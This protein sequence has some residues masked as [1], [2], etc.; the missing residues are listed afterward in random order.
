M[1][2]EAEGLQLRANPD[3]RAA[4]APDANGLA[5]LAK[6][7]T[8]S[9]EGI[10]RELRA[11]IVQAQTQTLR[12]RTAFDAI[13]QGVCYFD[14]ED[15]VLL[16]NRRF[17]EIY[18]LAP[19]QIRPGATLREIVELRVA[20]GT[21][22]AASAD[23]YLSFCASNHLS[24]ESIVWMTELRDG[25][26]IQMRR[27]PMPGGGCVVTYEDITELKAA[28]AAANERLSLQALI[29]RL[30]DNLW[31]KD[32]NSR[33]VIANQVTATRMGMAGPAEL[34][35]KTDLELLPPEI[36]RK[37]FAD[38]QEIIRTGHPMIDEEEY[39]SKTWIS[40]TKVPLRNERNEIFGVAGISRDITTRRLEDA[41]R[42]EQ[43]KILEMIAMSAPL[44]D[45]L[46]HLVLLME[47]QFKGIAGSILLVDE[48]GSRLRHGAAPSLPDTYAKAIDGLR[49]GPKVGPCGTAAYRREAVVVADIMT[50]PL[51]GD[52]KS[53]AAE[54]GLRSCWATP[55]LSHQGAVLGTFAM[56]SKEVR[57]PSDAELRLVDVATRI[58]GIAIERKLAEDRIHFM[59]NHDA[60]TGL[61]NR[62]LL[63]DR[64]S[65]AMLHARRDDRWVTALFT[66]IDN[67][68]FVNDSLGHNAGDELL[69]TIA[70]RMSDCIRATDTVV[71]LGGDEFV[72]VLSDQPK[73]ADTISQTVRKLQATISA[74]IRLEDHD[75]TITVSIGIASYPDD[76][77]DVDTL[78]GNADAAM[79]RAKEIGRDNFQFYT[80]ELNTK[81]HSKFLLQEELRAAVARSE[82]VLHYQPQVDL[83]TG[84]VF[85]VEAL[86][87]WNHPRL[88]LVPPLKFIPIAEESGLIVP[89]GDWVLNEACR[90]NKAWQ[91]A[92][93]PPIAVC[94]NVSARQFR[95]G[96]L[97]AQVTNAL[98]QTGLDAK[99]LEIEVTESLIMQDL[100][101]AIAT[102]TDLQRLGVELSI[103]DFGTGYSSLSALKTF[104]VSR[105]KIDKSFIDGLLANEND[106]AVTSAVIS[107]GQKLNL[108]VIAEGVENDAQATLLRNINCDEMQ[109]YLFSKPLPAKGVEELLSVTSG[110]PRTGT[111]N[112]AAAMIP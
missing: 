92:G 12:Y 71:R 11:E 84:R 110:Y 70:K 112:A 99:Y 53:L 72:I 19:E 26:L 20:A 81:A 3:T 90:Q 7:A 91:D 85:A 100:D 27:Q 41:L 97:V 50:D 78:L 95:E 55:I 39:V 5:T 58:A 31:V 33:F 96:N 46:E 108:R 49:I 32:V 54:H 6:L 88:G 103:D 10:E 98:T 83:R 75:V 1:A 52:Y 16:S 106:K 104:P 61:P 101:L 47:S 73:N 82:F 87:R 42:D 86:V 109:G 93:L 63:E 68:K 28:R 77:D 17:A 67:F 94:V 13:E 51:W 22:P 18:R 38:E 15:R 111:S 107:L 57:E 40:T 80:P 21:Y 34:T 4:T 74:P 66:D 48:T 65:Q 24:K 25:R 9:F 102:M 44:G 59:A 35:G 45:V 43:A 37:F 30:P 69:K 105:L 89:I 56:Y 36:A 8:S 79:Y 14:A 60:L 64:L 29:D 2:A 76:G 62:T 23:D